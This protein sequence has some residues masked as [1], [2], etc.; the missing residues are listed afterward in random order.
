M[1]KLLLLRVMKA[2]LFVAI[3]SA[4]A[5][6]LCS[7]VAGFVCAPSLAVKV[8]KCWPFAVRTAVLLSVFMLHTGTAVRSCT[9]AYCS[10]VMRRKSSAV[11]SWVLN[12]WLRYCVQQQPMRAYEQR[13]EMVFFMVLEIWGA[14]FGRVGI[15][16]MSAVNAYTMSVA[17]MVL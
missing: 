15:A 2:A 1:T 16:T 6:A 8:R 10:S 14:A 5:V 9:I 11:F 17:S 3:A 4:S 12:V 7:G 13:S